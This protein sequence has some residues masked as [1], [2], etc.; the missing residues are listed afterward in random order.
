MK[1]L[2]AVVGLVLLAVAWQAAADDSTF[3][4]PGR[5]F[6]LGD[7]LVAVSLF[8]WFSSTGGQ[9]TGP[10]RPVEG[11]Q[12]WTGTTAFWVRQLKDIMDANIDVMYVHLIPGWEQERIN[13]FEAMAQLRSQGYEVPKA[14][15]FLD[16]DITWKTKP[17][18]PDLATSAGKDTWVAQY[19]RFFQQYFSQNTDSRA[20]EFLGL[21]DGRVMLDTWHVLDVV[22]ANQ[23]TR[24]DVESRL[25][26]EF[27][28]VHPVFN[29]GVYQVV[30]PVGN[31][32]S[33]ADEASYQ[34]C[35]NEY[36]IEWTGSPQ[37]QTYTAK[38]GYWDQNIRNPGSFLARAGG[39]N[40]VGAWQ[41]IIADSPQHRRVYIESWNEYDEGS[42]IYAADPGP[43]YIVPPNPN[44]DVWSSTNN[45]REYI[46]TTATYAGQ[47]NGLPQRD[48]L[49]LSHTIPASMYPGE[50]VAANTV[51]R[52]TGNNQWSN[53]NSYKLGLQG[54]TLFEW[55][56]D[57]DAQGWTLV[58]NAFGTSGNTTYENG[59]W[60]AGYGFAGGGLR[61]RTGNVNSTLYTSGASTA[62][63]RTIH[64]DQT[65]NVIITFR[66]RLFF[67]SSY[68]SGE[69]G[70]ARFELDNQAYGLDGYTYLARYAGGA[71]VNQDTGWRTFA[72]TFTLSGP[73]DHTFEIG[74]WNNRKSA[75]DEVVD[76]YVDDVSVVDLSHT[77]PFGPSRYL[78]DDAG[79]EIPTYG[80]IFRGRP[81]T[82]ALQLTAPATPGTYDLNLQTLQ[83]GVVWFGPRL[84]VRVEVQPLAVNP[85]PA[86]GATGVH[87]AVVLTWTAGVGAVAHQVYFG[88]DPH[89]VANANT[90]SPEFVGSFLP[91]SEAYDPPGLLSQGVTY[92][93]RVD[94][95][96]QIGSVLRGRLWN[97]T[98]AVIPGDFDQDGDVDQADF[99]R[100]QACLSGGESVGPDCMTA[101][102]DRDGMVDQ[103]D[104]ARF[105]D[106]MGGPEQPPGC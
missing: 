71:G 1:R 16:T 21:I 15:P 96:T 95:V 44:T 36:M 104:F 45:P 38:G 43:P 53:A 97:F 10:W 54:P 103:G 40:Y 81:K 32:F 66:W 55:S 25:R 19:T 34:F 90:S 70:E 8:Q 48:A 6:M 87:P 74:G 46:D 100:F 94:E 82:F 5:T 77:S 73:A 72:G 27:G 47:Y 91:G 37:V 85:N 28:S 23:L 20:E 58:R 49:F 18:F 68:D 80:G 105:Y 14:V 52:N 84:C 17:P 88:L 35:T 69:Y 41:S 64:L 65:T 62:F 51:V 29:N 3:N 4:L 101:D 76:V 7:R 99:G 33:W 89:A 61:T 86:D 12:N 9:L 31:W 63:A 13:L 79:D 92:Y 78:I 93:W 39:V 106:C 60:G 67:P 30:T 102:L 75:A 98:T 83:E 59:D 24:S 26:T 22:N 11:R 50:V 56:F 2:F 42:G 57:S